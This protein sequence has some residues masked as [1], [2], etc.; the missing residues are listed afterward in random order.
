MNFFVTLGRSIK[1]F[2]TS[3]HDKLCCFFFK[4]RER[5]VRDRQHLFHQ[6]AAA[7]DFN[8]NH[9]ERATYRPHREKTRKLT[10]RPIQELRSDYKFDVTIFLRIK[11]IK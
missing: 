9:P 5:Q 11:I 2:Y 6:A 3:E 10:R 7:A 1:G 4:E 8:E